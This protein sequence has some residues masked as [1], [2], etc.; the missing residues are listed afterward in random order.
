M[1]VTEETAAQIGCI[2]YVLEEEVKRGGNENDVRGVYDRVVN[3]LE[4]RRI[5]G[6]DLAL[7]RDGHPFSSGNWN[8]RYRFTPEIIRDVAFNQFSRYVSYNLMRGLTAKTGY[9]GFDILSLLKKQI[10]EYANDNM[11][12]IL[13]VT[14]EIETVG[15]IVY[16]PESVTL[17]NWYS[18]LDMVA[19]KVS[20]HWG[21]P[22]EA[23]E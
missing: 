22:L 19:K 21:T 1:R 18:A 23:V 6:Y 14:K 15:A 5:C 3:F 13:S 10:A 20:Y 11:H 7:G 9:E 16:L 4:Q 2:K 17:H 12:K 8:N